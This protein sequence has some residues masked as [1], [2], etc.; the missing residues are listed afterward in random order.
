MLVLIKPDHTPIRVANK[1]AALVLVIC[2][3]S[4]L[5]P[6][7]QIIYPEVREEANPGHGPFVSNY[8]IKNEVY[9]LWQL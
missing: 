4:E 2:E 6:E 9:T 5:S 1:H 3:N 7:D 8:Y